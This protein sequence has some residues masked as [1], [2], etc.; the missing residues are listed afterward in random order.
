[1]E[2]DN[3]QKEQYKIITKLK[4]GNMAG[5]DSILNYVILSGGKELRKRQCG[6]IL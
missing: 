3:Y 6:L 2:Q 4:Q 1:M 5:P